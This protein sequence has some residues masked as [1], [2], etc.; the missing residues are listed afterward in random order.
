M[1]LQ[2]NKK[3]VTEP[4]PHVDTGAEQQNKESGGDAEKSADGKK[5]KKVFHRS[6]T[7]KHLRAF[8][9]TALRDGLKSLLDKKI[10]PSTG[11][12][13][14]KLSHEQ[15]V[16]Y[17]PVWA[18][19]NYYKAII[20][21]KEVR[22]KNAPVLTEKQKRIRSKLEKHSVKNIL[23]CMSTADVKISGSYA[24]NKADLS[25]AVAMHEK[26]LDILHLVRDLQA[27]QDAKK[28]AEAESK[29]RSS[30]SSS[31]SSDQD[32]DDSEESSSSDEEDQPKHHKKN[33]K[34]PHKKSKSSSSK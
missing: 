32:E 20:E 12:N 3:T 34:H 2:N 7:T 10:V 16:T 5:K 25:Q 27:Q 29:K 11:V 13:I 31:S 4:L 33:K 26:G 1:P 9:E 23:A 21:Q 8:S 19:A 14:N 6:I 22:E 30:S 28:L 24:M 17:C 15:L 18:V